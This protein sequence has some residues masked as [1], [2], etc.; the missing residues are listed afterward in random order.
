MAAGKWYIE[1]GRLNGK[2]V[3]R[4][5]RTRDSE[6]FKEQMNLEY[7]G[8]FCTDLGAVEALV[9]ILNRKAEEEEADHV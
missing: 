7:Y 1:T 6:L 5:V 3:Y 4:A 8:T 2:R 9:N